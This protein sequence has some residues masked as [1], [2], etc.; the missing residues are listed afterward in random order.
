MVLLGFSLMSFTGF[1]GE[2][3]KIKCDVEV[4]TDITLKTETKARRTTGKKRK[5][6]ILDKVDQS[7]TLEKYFETRVGED[8]VSILLDKDEDV[9]LSLVLDEGNL[10]MGLRAGSFWTRKMADDFVIGVGKLGFSFSRRFSF[11]EKVGFS[12]RYYKKV[13]LSEKEVKF[14]CE[15]L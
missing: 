6:I 12:N 14:W 8:M 7:H 5:K 10:V 2:S 13:E 4:H 9:K 15:F 1:A 11:E 3:V